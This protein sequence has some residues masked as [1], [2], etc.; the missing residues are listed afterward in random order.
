V[1]FYPRDLLGL[2]V[3]IV[4]KISLLLIHAKEELFVQAVQD[5]EW[6]ILQNI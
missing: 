1:A 6:P 3:G 2:I 4:K 5:E